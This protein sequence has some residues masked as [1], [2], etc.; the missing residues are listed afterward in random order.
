MARSGEFAPNSSE[1]VRRSLLL[2]TAIARSWSGKAKGNAST[3]CEPYGGRPSRHG[4]LVR[5]PTGC[6]I[7]ISLYRCPVSLLARL[8]ASSLGNGAAVLLSFGAARE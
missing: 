1:P 3:Y 8:A 4:L 2:T 7:A 6:C 5:S